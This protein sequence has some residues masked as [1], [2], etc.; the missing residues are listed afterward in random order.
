MK[1]GYHPEE[2]RQM[3]RRAGV[4]HP[5]LGDLLR[6]DAVV[7]ETKPGSSE[8]SPD[9]LFIHLSVTGRCN[10]RCRGCINS[11]VTGSRSGSG[12]LISDTD[13]ERDAACI[14]ALMDLDG[15]DEAVV[16]LYGGE[17]LLEIEKIETLR[18]RLLDRRE[19]R[20]FRFLLYTNGELLADACRDY[21]E[22]M[23]DLWLVCVSVDGR[24]A[25]HRRIRQ[26]TS[27]RRIRNGLAAL[28]ALGQEKVLVWSTL[29]EGQSLRDCFEAF[30]DLHR[31]GL[32]DQFF[33]HWVEARDPF[34]AFPAY[35]ESYEAD[36]AGI[37][38]EYLAWLSCGRILPVVH[39][40]ELVFFL[41]TGRER[42]S[43]ACA[44]ERERN[45]DLADGRLHACADL[46]AELAI[47]RI[48]E[49]GAPVLR[50]SSLL[51]DLV[52]YKNDL[53]CLECGVHAYCGGRCPVQAVAGSA[54]RLLQY[55][56]LMRLHVGS[57]KDLLDG[58]RAAMTANGLAPR[59]LMNLS[60]RLA[61]FTDVTP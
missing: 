16:C 36:L 49:D 6:P 11:A 51:N 45:F 27:L 3:R 56:Q 14:H 2:L 61:Q 30:R 31:Q 33:W 29:R 26:G 1:F 35:L 55:C 12:A 58:I 34:D 17:P 38:E 44:V 22:L 20:S 24:A 41:L 53:G 7:L 18:S 60:G 52:G 8:L 19:K 48:A 5:R 25:Q 42:G 21:P 59:D 46:P 43:T 4:I 23:R 15:A 54:G 57:V 13:P 39:L 40:N 32:A 28:R 47:G 50:P 10:A 9:P 37:L